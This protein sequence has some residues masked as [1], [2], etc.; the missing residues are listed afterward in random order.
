MA[1]STDKDQK[2]DL[3]PPSRVGKGLANNV[4]LPI[5]PEILSRN[6]DLNCAAT[7]L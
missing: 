3:Y 5:Q 1:L 4:S 2:R 6:D 7:P